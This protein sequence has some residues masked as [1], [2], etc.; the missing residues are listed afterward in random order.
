[1]RPPSPR[2]ERAAGLA[3]VVAAVLF[4]G[5][6]SVV[7]AWTWRSLRS[8]WALDLV[9]FHSQVWNVARGAGFAQSVHW[10]ESQSL[11]GNTHFNPIILLG[12]P[13]QWVAPGLDSLLALQCGLVALG[14]VGVARLARA[15][16][17]GPWLGVG[18]ACAYWMQAPLW[19]LA[20]SDLRP[21]VWSIPFL[22]LLAGALTAQRRREA[23]LWGLLACLCR[24]EMPAVVAALAL[25][26]AAGA[27][28][29]RR[30]WP[31]ALTVAGGAFTVLL[32]TTW[33]RPAAGTYIEPGMWLQEAL[34]WP[35]H[36][37]RGVGPEPLWVE[38]FWPRLA[39]LARWALPLGALSLLAPRV[40]L[41][42]VPLLGYLMT[43]DVEWADWSGA[44]GHYTAPA[45]A[46]LAAAAAAGLGH[47]TGQGAT[48]TAPFT[49]P[50]RGARP[51]RRLVPWLALGAVL[52]VESGQAVEALRGWVAD[53]TLAA[54]TGD[55]DL[56]RVRALAA[57]VPP[58]APVMTDFTTVALFAGRPALY[59]YER[60][61]MQPEVTADAGGPLLPGRPVQPQWALIAARDA[62][63][64]ARAQRFGLVERGRSNTLVL[65]GPPGTL[66]PG[67]ASPAPQ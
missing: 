62:D 35:L 38:R 63:W 5:F 59:S 39:W 40:L 24:E 67:E 9:Y 14:G 58:D 15:H 6:H 19:R 55:P 8:D 41:G 21:L 20:Q 1:M 11:L 23:V 53:D 16:G 43:T 45:L 10:H 32:V 3:V 46:L 60:D 29:F 64:I 27:G 65:L 37:P 25:A 50:A 7:A 33:L 49:G 30:R 56:Q 2:T 42:A 31:L 47:L 12:V 36:L 57:L 61:A 4:A 18:A 54:R 48:G 52:A 13:L 28:A 66:A 44:G 26:H 17:A 22:V 34:G 51:G